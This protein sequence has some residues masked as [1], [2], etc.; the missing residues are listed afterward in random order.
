MEEKRNIKQ[1]KDNPQLLELM[2]EDA[3]SASDLY[4][5]TNY[6]LNYE[7]IFLLELRSL[8]LKNFRRRKNSVLSSFGATDLLP[9]SK[10]LHPLPRLKPASS[11]NKIIYLLFKIKKIEKLLKYISRVISDVDYQDVRYLCYEFVK[12]YGEKNGAKSIKELET[13]TIGNP[14]D[15]FIIDGNIYTISLLY[16]YIQYAYCSQF[17]DFNSIDT[18]MEIGS[19]SG[20]QIEVIKKLYPDIC[21]YVFEIPPQL[22]VCEQYLSAIFPDSVVSYTETR[23]MKKIPKNNKGKIYIFGNFKLPEIININYDLFWNSASFQEMEPDVV[24]NYLKYVNKQTKKYVF[25]H[26]LM[27]GKECASKK[28]KPGVLKQTTIAHYEKGLENFLLLDLSRSI[29]L[30]RVIT[31]YSFS[32][33]KKNIL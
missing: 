1:V 24:L 30:P 20:K 10:S 12:Y 21:F 18:I 27:E 32:F 22:Y 6:W 3:K 23:T 15:I 8:G 14:E 11:I 2:L 16:Y 33:W 25:L 7:K 19:G 5:P 26:E 9:I 17:I 31:P 28:G 29:F 4:K 13:S